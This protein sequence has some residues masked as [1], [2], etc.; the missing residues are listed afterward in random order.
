MKPMG[1]GR[2][3]GG[4]DPLSSKLQELLYR[5]RKRRNWTVRD[6]AAAAGISPSYV[7]LIENGHKSP[8]PETLER[9]GK[10][11]G[12][13][14]ELLDAMVTL[15]RRPADPMV[16]T[17][18]FTTLVNRLDELESSDSLTVGEEPFRMYAAALQAP[19]PAMASY[20]AALRTELPDADR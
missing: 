19:S 9:I 18:A 13:D 12:I 15:Q 7:S 5:S 3:R 1:P 10:A 14:R 17:S 20:S 2:S 4:R 6:L 8:D 16:T 11:L